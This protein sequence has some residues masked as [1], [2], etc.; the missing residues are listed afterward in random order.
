MTKW[1]EDIELETL[2]PLGVH[3][4]EKAEIIRFAQKIDPQ[5][6][7]VSAEKAVHS[8]F[9][10]LIASGWHTACIGH[11]LLVDA[12]HAQKLEIESTGEKAGEAGPSP[13]VNNMTFK[14][15][16][17]PGDTVSYDFYVES[18]RPSK[19]LPGWGLVIQRLEAHNQRGE[20]VYKIQFAGFV[21]MR[22]YK[23]TMAEMIK[24][25]AIA[26]PLLRKLVA[27]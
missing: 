10:E 23:P 27:R 26:Q 11:R 22:D 2:Y 1:F 3:R 25:W 4:F 18:K 24:A 8:E 6:F 21:R 17:K 5:Y 19:S 9:G 13:G 7:H 16:V 20:Q 15:P 14:T 12:M